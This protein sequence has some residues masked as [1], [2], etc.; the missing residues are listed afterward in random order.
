MEP[1]FLGSPSTGDVE[2]PEL[3]DF[4]VVSVIN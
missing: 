4:A 1:S 3:P 2:V